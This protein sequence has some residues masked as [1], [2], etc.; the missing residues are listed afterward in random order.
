MS[1]R[2]GLDETIV[3]A[4]GIVEATMHTLTELI[5]G[6]P[7]FLWVAIAFNVAV[8]L[9]DP[10]RKAILRRV[11]EWCIFAYCIVSG[12]AMNWALAY[13]W[14]FPRYA[15]SSGPVLRAMASFVGLNTLIGFLASRLLGGKLQL[16]VALFALSS[17]VLARLFHK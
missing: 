3:F 10:W 8:V 15:F 7:L 13:S 14:F 9:F 6:I 5:W 1:C 4:A 12:L 16:D 2:V 11:P 17:C